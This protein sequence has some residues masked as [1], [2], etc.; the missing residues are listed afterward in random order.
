MDQLRPVGWECAY[1]L[2]Q[3]HADKLTPQH[4]VLCQIAQFSAPERC[5]QPGALL[6]LYLHV[7]GVRP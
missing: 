7:A 4:H 5:Q 1:A 2:I 3:D 6:A